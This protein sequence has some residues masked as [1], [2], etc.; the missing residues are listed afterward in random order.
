MGHLQ[1]ALADLLGLKVVEDGLES[2][3]Q[4][5]FGVGL[6]MVAQDVP[7]NRQVKALDADE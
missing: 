6:Q 4:I 5:Q 7:G 2:G 1:P 3:S